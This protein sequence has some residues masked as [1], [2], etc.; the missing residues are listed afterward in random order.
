[1]KIKDKQKISF[2]ISEVLLGRFNKEIQTLPL[3]RDQFLSNLIK[4][5]CEY[6]SSDLHGKKLSDEAKA[7]ISRQLKDMEKGTRAV[8]IVIDKDVAERLN[9]IVQETNIVRD[10]FINSLIYF[11]LLTD[12][13]Q[14]KI[15]IDQSEAYVDSDIQWDAIPISP[16]KWIEKVLADPFCFLREELP[17][18]GCEQGLYLIPMEEKFVGFTCYAEYSE[19]PGTDAYKRLEEEFL[20]SIMKI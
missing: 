8:S 5:E 1:M 16:I 6:L 3:A 4:T 19:L 10:A 12:R 2:R 11:L 13:L 14:K 7:F 20:N 9:E 17:K 15:G 18:I